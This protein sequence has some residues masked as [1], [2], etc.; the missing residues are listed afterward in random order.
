MPL[1]LRRLLPTLSI[2]L[3]VALCFASSASA[4]TAADV[5]RKWGLLGTWAIDCAK[6][7]KRRP[8]NTISYEVTADGGLVYRRDFNPSDNN[9]V[10]DA[11]IEPDDTLILSIVL[12]QYKNQRRENGI[13]MRF[14][15]SI[16]S[17]FN[18]GV[19][20]TYTIRDGRFV[21]NGKPTPILRK[22]AED[23]S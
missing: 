20:G 2:A 21:H 1:L 17:V 19:D 9:E 3:C 13:E 12:P 4:E 14:D 16:R 22:C 6:P 11:R 7:A 23:A 10:A 8:G 15:G 5:A 18:R